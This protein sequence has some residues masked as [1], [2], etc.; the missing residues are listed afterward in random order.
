MKK[1]VLRECERIAVSKNEL[2]PEW[3]VG[4]HHFSFI[5]QNNKII[6][7]GMNRAGPPLVEFGYNEKFGKIHA[8]T[9]AYRKARGILDLSRTFEVVNIRLNKRGLLRLSKPCG[10]CYE[11][12]FVMGC[13]AVFFSTEI[14]FAKMALTV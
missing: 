5:I 9:D 13:K 10:C 11:F 6:E 3:G 1:T 8:E 14:G 2:H 4:Y 12:L 7:M